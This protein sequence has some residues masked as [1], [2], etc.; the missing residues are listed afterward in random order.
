MFESVKFRYI[1]GLVLHTKMAN[2][3]ILA[4]VT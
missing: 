4:L 1:C 2:R 3:L